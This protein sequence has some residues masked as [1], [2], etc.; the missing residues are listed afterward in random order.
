MLL[1]S[2]P[3]DVELGVVPQYQHMSRGIAGRSQVLN[4]FKAV[5]LSIADFPEP[6][7]PYMTNGLVEGPVMYSCI[8]FNSSSRP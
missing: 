3:S 4:E 7:A 5:L 8:F 2:G 1:R 6:P